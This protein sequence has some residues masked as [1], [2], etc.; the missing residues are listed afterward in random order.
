[1]KFGDGITLESFGPGLIEVAGEKGESGDLQDQIEQLRMEI[2]QLRA[3]LDK[4]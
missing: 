1:M 3:K 4:K 2:E